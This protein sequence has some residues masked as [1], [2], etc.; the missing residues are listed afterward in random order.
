MAN[1]STLKAAI[2]NIIKTNGNQ[3]ITGKLLQSALNSIVSSVGENAAFAGVAT[4]ETNPGAPDGHVFYLAGI[5][6]IYSNFGVTVQDEIAV[7][8]NN[9]SGS[10]A[11]QSIISAATTEKA[12][13]MSAKDKKTLD[14]HSWS[15]IRVL[16][17][18]SRVDF[19]DSVVGSSNTFFDLSEPI[20]VVKGEKLK[21]QVELT[22]TNS[23]IIIVYLW[24]SDAYVTEPNYIG[25]DTT[26]ITFNI[27]ADAT[28]TRI[29]LRGD[30]ILSG[31]IST[32][33]EGAI[34]KIN[35]NAEEIQ[36]IK[37]TGYDPAIVEGSYL[38][39]SGEAISDAGYKHTSFIHV[40]EGATLSITGRKVCAYNTNKLFVSVLS[41]S[42]GDIIIPSQVRY[43]RVDAAKTSLLDITRYG[44]SLLGVALLQDV[45]NAN[46]A[47]NNI[48]SKFKLSSGYYATNGIAQAG[49]AYVKTDYIYVS[50]NVYFTIRP[51]RACFYDADKKFV[52]SIEAPEAHL[53][54]PG[55]AMYVTFSYPKTDVEGKNL[56]IHGDR[57]NEFIVYKD[58]LE[59]AIKQLRE[60]VIDAYVTEYTNNLTNEQDSTASV[61]GGEY[62]AVGAKYSLPVKCTGKY[63]LHFEFKYPANVDGSRKEILHFDNI[64]GSVKGGCRVY[65]DNLGYAIAEQQ[66][67]SG[68]VVAL[69]PI[70]S[71]NNYVARVN[72][73]P[74]HISLQTGNDA[75]SLR[76][77][78]SNQTATMSVTENG[79]VFIGVAEVNTIPFPANASMLDFANTLETMCAEGGSLNGVFEFTAYDVFGRST[80]DLT[81]VA[82]IPLYYTYSYGADNFPVFVPY[83]DDN[84]HSVDIVFDSSA[85]NGW[86]LLSFFFDGHRVNYVDNGFTLTGN[87][88]FNTSVT[89]GGDGIAVRNLK[90]TDRC[91]KVDAP[92]INIEMLHSIKDELSLGGQDKISTS[93]IERVITVYKKHGYKHIPLSEI[94]Q[95]MR[96]NKALS[97]KYFCLVHDDYFYNSPK[98]LNLY[99]GMGCKVCFAII[100]ELLSEEVAEEYKK[101]SLHFEY[102]IHSETNYASLKYDLL[103]QK[104]RSDMAN[105]GNSLNSITNMLVYPYGATNRGIGKVLFHEGI[106]VA[107]T[108]GG[109]QVSMNCNPMILPRMTTRATGAFENLDSQLANV[110]KYYK[111]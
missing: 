66:I 111:E 103:V 109:D 45:C 17:L 23:N 62:G 54:V 64:A 47:F 2:A 81:K 48:Y 9:S 5:S 6:G 74:S 70:T 24:S 49:S 52:S 35:H 42:G 105:L 18:E 110:D 85:T 34:N 12:G 33:I 1:W 99:K 11:K 36:Q 108:V 95:Y 3:E 89:I 4:P 100:N 80:A 15:I 50:S 59:G 37:S 51:L 98:L 22:A 63:S 97:G 93:E 107:I 31:S 65:L 79:L 25:A 43:I 94:S 84:W 56:I 7:I 72:T 68:R 28:I 53:V 77:L 21:F 69:A 26:E 30:T 76:Y 83:N 106:T 61:V 58:E 78:G 87:G 39:D 32:V 92:V 55:N 60:D 96:G 10:W 101:N 88:V 46:D 41:N 91:T 57:I 40:I 14:K 102:A 19:N 73:S 67:R 104:I 38:S 8:A 86:D 44:S 13:V 75:F 29:S 71:D 20:S 27:T 16:G 82:N 90:Y